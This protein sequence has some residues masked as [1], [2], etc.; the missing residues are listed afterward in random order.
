[1]KVRNRKSRRLRR[2]LA[3]ALLVFLSLLALPLYVIFE[4]VY[5]Q[6]GME[7]FYARRIAAE[8]LL[9][10]IDDLIV[11]IVRE[12]EGREFSEYGYFKVEQQ[13]L[14]RRKGLSLSPLSKIP[15][16][17]NVPGIIGYFQ[18]DPDGSF[19]SPVLPDVS[20]AEELRAL[21]MS[22]K[23]EEYADRVKRRD[24]IKNIFEASSLFAGV[25]KANEQIA[26][27]TGQSLQDKLSKADRLLDRISGANEWPRQPQQLLNV[28]EHLAE[29]ERRED[30]RSAMAPNADRGFSSGESSGAMSIRTPQKM[31]IDVPREQ[32]AEVVSSFLEL[33]AKKVPNGHAL[34]DEESF[35]QSRQEIETFE[36]E[37]D[38]IQ[39]FVVDS[40]I[41]AFVRRVWRGERRYL[42]G[43][44]VDLGGFLDEAVEAPFLSSA[45]A[46]M[47]VLEIVHNGASLKR[48]VAP[49]QTSGRL[50]TQGRELEVKEGE[51]SNVLYRAGLAVPLEDLELVFK[52]GKISPGA[53]ALVVNVLAGVLIVVLVGGVLGVYELVSRQIDLAEERSDFVAAVSHELKTPLTSIRMYAEM[54]KSGWVLDE[55]K[56][57]TYYD[58][59]FAESERLSRLVANVLQVA[60]LSHDD[61]MLQLKKFEVGELVALA[62]K[63]VQTQV[64]GAGFVLRVNVEEDGKDIRHEIIEVE[65]DAFSQIIIN[66]VD[67]AIKFSKN[68][69][70]KAVELSVRRIDREP[71]EVIFAVRDFGPGIPAEQQ[72]KIFQLFY[73]PGSELTRTTAGTGIGLAL[74]K[75]L[76][77]KMNARV[78][79]KNATPGVEFLVGFPLKSLN[80]A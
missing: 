16:E 55:Q 6:L 56:K 63:K 39:A 40:H 38:P 12:E 37:I 64:D 13:E 17:S 15:P 32:D 41:L 3:L 51:A 68:G 11:N 54:L 31:E 72:K 71:R 61:S 21:G 20:S 10:R 19:H 48:V 23:L 9:H 35:W 4:K 36:G 26:E 44:F 67:N 47:S 25:A 78:D 28:D 49:I 33:K 76:A 7:A 53:G 8:E 27:T 70:E 52:I 73:R 65:E 42:Q 24:E 1:M 77:S 22:V 5:A 58:F 34:G 60:R 45:I 30:T 43:F 2:R 18:V 66:L 50:Y 79:L 14:W 57:G 74:V 62:Q 69:E 46:R 29:K 75:E 59:I 80:A